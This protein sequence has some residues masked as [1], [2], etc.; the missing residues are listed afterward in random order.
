MWHKLRRHP[1]GASHDPAIASP[2]A[3]A[4]GGCSIF[5]VLKTA[6]TGCGGSAQLSAHIHDSR[7]RPAER[8]PTSEKVALPGP[9]PTPPK[10]NPFARPRSCDG[11]HAATRRLLAGQT[12]DSPMP[13]RNNAHRGETS[14]MGNVFLGGRWLLLPGRPCLATGGS[15][16]ATDVHT[17]GTIPARGDFELKKQFITRSC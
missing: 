13:S 7:N 17:T 2:V 11:I 16:P 10:I 12:I 4:P 14:W 5:R 9:S 1:P 6:Q 15:G 8:P 3:S